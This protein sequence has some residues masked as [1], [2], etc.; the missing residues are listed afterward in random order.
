M[1]RSVFV[2]PIPR[3]ET[4]CRAACLLCKDKY[5]KP[6][7]L[8]RRIFRRCVPLCWECLAQSPSE[9]LENYGLGIGIRGFPRKLV[10]VRIES[11][12][13][14]GG[15]QIHIRNFVL[16]SFGGLVQEGI[17]NAPNFPVDT[18]PTFAMGL[19]W[20]FRPLSLLRPQF[21]PGHILVGTNFSIVGILS[22]PV[23]S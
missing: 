8:W 4:P 21:P 20:H 19:A 7:I 17:A 18:G 22:S 16:C 10:S 2:R 1:S 9:L 11:T 13:S 15:E 5:R 12:V 6:G 23:K 3:L 14:R